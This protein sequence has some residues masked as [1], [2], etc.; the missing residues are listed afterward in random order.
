MSIKLVD[1]TDIASTIAI[2]GAG[3]SGTL[4]ASHLLRAG[5]ARIVLIERAGRVGRGVAYGTGFSGHLLNVPAASMSGLPDDSEHFLRFARREHDAATEPTT[6][7]PRLVYGAYLESLLAESEQL[8]APG[9]SLQRRQAEVVDLAPGSGRQPWLLKLGD[10]SRVR[11]DCVVL[12]LGNL[13]PNDPALEAG[14]WP[15]DQRA[16]SATPGGQARWKAARQ[17]PPSSSAPD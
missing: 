14:S 2:V 8:A 17:A 10:G 6:F 11:A 9:A 7:V 5:N 3:A 4:L 13:P 16:T 15:E 12:A 1:T